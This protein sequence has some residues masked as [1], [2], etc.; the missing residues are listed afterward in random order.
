[1][2]TFFIA[3]RHW[4]SKQLPRPQLPKSTSI[5]NHPFQ[6]PQFQS[7]GKKFDSS[8]ERGTPLEIPIGMGMLIRGWDEGVP[9][10]SL[11]EKALL[12]VGHEVKYLRLYCFLIFRVKNCC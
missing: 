11:G 7:N 3:N 8:L 6:F 2:L 10:M 5:S 9:T 12:Y 4:T 1:M